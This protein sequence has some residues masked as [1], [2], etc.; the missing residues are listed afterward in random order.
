MECCIYSIDVWNAFVR[1]GGTIL[2]PV[3]AIFSAAPQVI[4]LN[5]LPQQDRHV[6]NVKVGQQVPMSTSHAHGERDKQVAHI[7]EMTREPYFNK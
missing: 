4:A 5:A 7:I 2:L 6:D 3:F 1:Y